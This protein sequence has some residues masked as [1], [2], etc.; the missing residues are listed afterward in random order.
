MAIF[1][2]YNLYLLV[3]LTR[4]GEW[5]LCFIILLW[6]LK[7]SEGQFGGKFWIFPLEFFLGGYEP[8][9]D[10][11]GGKYF[12]FLLD[13]TLGHNSQSYWLFEIESKKR[14][15]VWLS[16]LLSLILGDW[17]SRS[18]SIG[19]RA[20]A[21]FG[22]LLNQPFIDLNNSFPINFHDK[23]HTLP[24]QSSPLFTYLHHP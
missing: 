5:S 15:L 7:P 24:L 21:S 10:E 20:R 9:R 4:S 18:T 8:L 11:L 16:S 2:H 12:I 23:I 19:I 14:I 13:H 3:Y 22:C 17:G 6:W 1:S